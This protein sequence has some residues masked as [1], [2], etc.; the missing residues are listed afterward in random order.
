MTFARQI[1]SSVV[2]DGSLPA[3]YWSS[4]SFAPSSSAPGPRATQTTMADS[5][6]E[7]NELEFVRVLGTRGSDKGGCG[8]A[9]GGVRACACK[10]GG[11]CTCIRAQNRPRI[12]DLEKV[13]RP[14]WG[15]VGC[16]QRADGESDVG[17]STLQKSDSLSHRRR[18]PHVLSATPQ[19]VSA[20]RSTGLRRRA[21]RQSGIVNT[22]QMCQEGGRACGMDQPAPVRALV[23]PRP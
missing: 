18:R 5:R 13:A 10:C 12:R 2:P 1:C 20:M 6:R 11:D 3:R 21:A 4:N 14:M 22:E 15:C 23:V 16:M 7:S 9:R 19:A 8:G 17:F